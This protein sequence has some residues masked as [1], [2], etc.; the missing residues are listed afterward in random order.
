MR[1]DFFF[2]GLNIQV[3]ITKVDLSQYESR[4]WMS[5]DI[6]LP[7]TYSNAVEG[8]MGNFNG[9]ADDDLRSRSGRV[10][11]PNSTDEVIYNTLVSCKQNNKNLFFFVIF[12]N[13]NFDLWLSQG[14]I[15]PSEGDED[16]FVAGLHSSKMSKTAKFALRSSHDFTPVFFETLDVDATTHQLCN[17]SRQCIYDTIVTGLLGVGLSAIHEANAHKQA[18]HI[19]GTST[20][21][22]LLIYLELTFYF[23]CSLKTTSHLLSSSEIVRSIWTGVARTR[24][25]ISSRILSIRTAC[26]LAYTLRTRR[27]TRPT[28]TP[29]T[30]RIRSFKSSIVF[31]AASILSLGKK[32]KL[33]AIENIIFLSLRFYCCCFFLF[34]IIA[35]DSKSRTAVGQVDGMLICNCRRSH[36]DTENVCVYDQVLFK[37]NPSISM[38][39]C[40]CAD[41]YSGK[42]SEL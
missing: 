23:D 39:A 9:Q 42:K 2:K 38:V 33:T 37:V 7:K 18:L 24:Q 27:S 40:Q 41:Y 25:W 15:S 6:V 26:V 13:V 8:L 34:R 12:S 3:K 22:N 19:I 21:I 14:R 28:Y 16:L 17:G 10:I 31:D 11:S 29:S 1:C 20:F 30:K 4:S 35:T 32:K 36:D 5:V